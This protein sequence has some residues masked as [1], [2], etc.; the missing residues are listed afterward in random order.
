VAGVGVAA[1]RRTRHRADSTGTGCRWA[2]ADRAQDPILAVTPDG[3]IA[4]ANPSA[5]DLFVPGENGSALAGRAITEVL[6]GRLASV[7]PARVAILMRRFA[8][9]RRPVTVFARNGKGSKRE[10]EATFALQDD[11]QCT[12]VAILRDVTAR[13]RAERKL[14]RI[15]RQEQHAARRVERLYELQTAQLHRVL[16]ELNEPIGVVRNMTELLLAMNRRT[17]SESDN[18]KVLRHLHAA[19]QEAY[20]VLTIV[21]ESE[22]S[23]PEYAEL[24]PVDVTMLV[25]RCVQRFAARHRQEVVTV[26]GPLRAR[27]DAS[28]FETI[29]QN[30]LNNAAKHGG[31]VGPV[32]IRLESTASG[33]V[34]AVEDHG[35]GVPPGERRAIFDPFTRGRAATERGL[36]LGLSLVRR[37]ATS[38]GGRAWVTDTPGG[39]ASFM[40]FLPSLSLGSQQGGETSPRAG[41]PPHARVAG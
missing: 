31:P 8:E 26:A 16:H 23:R 30:L 9:R 15:V 35:P 40:V 36:G 33:I 12:C 14:R 18:D 19:S 32:T 1:K 24:S 20:R 6:G 10:V 17:T 2:V 28:H 13:N 37:L 22:R 11:P 25:Q 4:Y 39:G 21:A 29:L 5:H 41:E 34:L 27:I 3:R 7:D 38:D